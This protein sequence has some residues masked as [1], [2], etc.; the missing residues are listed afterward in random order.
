MLLERHQRRQ[1][2]RRSLRPEPLVHRYPV[3]DLRQFERKLTKFNRRRRLYRTRPVGQLRQV[4]VGKYCYDPIRKQPPTHPMK[5]PPRLIQLGQPMPPAIGKR[6]PLTI[7]LSPDFTDPSRVL[8]AILS[9]AP[10]SPLRR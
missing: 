3:L 4:P 6:L 8:I 1:S 9:V 5:P 10:I 2:N 7:M